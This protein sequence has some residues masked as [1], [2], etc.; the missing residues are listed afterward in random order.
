[1]KT[2]KFNHDAKAGGGHGKPE[3]QNPQ[4][5]GNIQAFLQHA[6]KLSKDT[7]NALEDA[8]NFGLVDE[9]K[10]TKLKANQAEFEAAIAEGF[11]TLTEA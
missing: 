2:V 6:E 4:D 11:K 9:T 3:E 10:Y 8:K 1:M 5:K 7:S